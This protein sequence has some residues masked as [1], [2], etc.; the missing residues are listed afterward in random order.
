[1]EIRKFRSRDREPL[2]Q[3]W[4][5]VFPDDPAHNEPSSVLEAKLKVDDL[6]FVVEQEGGIVGACIAGYDGHRGWLYAVAVEPEYRRRGIGKRLV[7]TAMD[8]LKEMGCIKV[9]IQI[10]STNTEVAAFYRSLGYS[11][12]DRLSMGAFL[13]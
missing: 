7:Q 8:S 9:N 6:I 5:T 2:I 13:N 11:V 3:L 4:K 1:M 12:E 10:R